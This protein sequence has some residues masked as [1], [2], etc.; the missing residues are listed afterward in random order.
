MTARLAEMDVGRLIALR[1][2]EG[3]PACWRAVA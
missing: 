3:R 1:L 2:P